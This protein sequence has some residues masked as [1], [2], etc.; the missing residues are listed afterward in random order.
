METITFNII[1]LGNDV[2]RIVPNDIRSQY[3]EIAD[4]SCILSLDVMLDHMEY[5]KH[6]VK[7][8]YGKEVVFQIHS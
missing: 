3:K 5:I 8:R 7:E 1:K 2:C 6:E 4:G